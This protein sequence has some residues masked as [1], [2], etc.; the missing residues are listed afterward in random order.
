MPRPPSGAAAPSSPR[1]RGAQRQREIGPPPALGSEAPPW[2]SG[3]LR[4]RRALW[5]TQEPQ[6][7]LSACGASRLLQQVRGRATAASPPPP[8]TGEPRGGS[9]R[10][11]G[12]SGCPEPS[13]EACRAGWVAWGRERPALP[14]APPPHGTAAGRSSELLR[15]LGPQDTPREGAFST[16]AERRWQGKDGPPASV[17]V[18]RKGNLPAA[19]TRRRAPAASKVSLHL[20]VT[21]AS[22]ARTKS[23]SMVS[24]AEGR[25]KQ[26][27][28]PQRAREPQEHPETLPSSSQRK[29]HE[30]RQ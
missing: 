5:W 23:L 21:P 3:V 20:T 11:L 4:A 30:K 8:L 27:L 1:G 19:Q 17:A 9:D 16:G 14:S 18:G 15:S 29:A 26:T 13:P 24:A 7:A 6:A 22:A 2:G 12:T 10:L 28:S 25:G